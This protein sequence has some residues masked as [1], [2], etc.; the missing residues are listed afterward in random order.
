MD[1]QQVFA[2]FVNRALL[3]EKAER[4]VALS[5][6][7]KGQRKILDGLCHQFES[8]IRPD[9]VRKNNYDKLWSSCC[10]VFYSPLGFGVEFASVR[11]A[12]DK[13]SIADSWLI[14]LH[15]ASAGIHRP[16]ARWD[17]EKLIIG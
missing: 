9:A 1:A 16:E 10:Y 6:T 11:E 2:K 15:D 5:E 13:L 14:I 7:K 17:D 12:Y 3:K 4:F 8:A